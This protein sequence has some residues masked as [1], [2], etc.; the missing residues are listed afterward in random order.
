[1]KYQKNDGENL[2]LASYIC[3]YNNIT[4]W[5]FICSFVPEKKTLWWEREDVNVKPSSNNQQSLII[6]M[7]K[8][9]KSA[10]LWSCTG[11]TA[12]LVYFIKM[13]LEYWI[14]RFC[15]FNEFSS[16]YQAFNIYWGFFFRFFSHSLGRVFV[17]ANRFDWQLLKKTPPTPLC[18]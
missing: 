8:L 3:G 13:H 5:S 2:P 4:K 6:W 1:M 12:E 7:M 16:Q 11:L 14:F 15:L 9:L 18:F 10:F 17:T